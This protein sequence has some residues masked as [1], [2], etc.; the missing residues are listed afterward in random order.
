MKL[1]RPALKAQAQNVIRSSN[2]KAIYSGM[3]V[4][5][6]TILVTFLSA[7]LLGFQ[8]TQD[9]LSQYLQHVENGNYDYALQFLESYSPSAASYLIDLAMQIVMK[10]ISVGFIIFLL[11]TIRNTGACFGN[12][13]DGF[14]MFWRI[15]LL[16]LLEWIFI[17]LWSLLLFVPGIIAAYRYRMAIYLMIDHPEM[18]ISQCIKESK[19]MMA[20]HKWEMF[21]LDLSFIGWLILSSIPYLGYVVRIW[22]LPYINT[23]YAL[24]YIALCGQGAQ[25]SSSAPNDSNDGSWRGNPPWES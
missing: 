12:I 22:T 1:N 14:G 7:K 13:L 20:G 23:T 11:N 9:E 15:I 24:Y 10:I 21:V 16:N 3:I 4:L 8:L 25:Q 6:L 18:S 5:A 17:T 19:R 2:P